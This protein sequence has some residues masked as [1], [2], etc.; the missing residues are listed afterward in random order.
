MNTQQTLQ[1]IQ[2]QLDDLQLSMRQNL[3]NVQSLQ[4]QV[5]RLMH[6]ATQKTQESKKA[7]KILIVTMPDNRQISYST[8]VQTFLTVIDKIGIEKVRILNLTSCGIPL[9]A[10]YRSETYVQQRKSICGKYWVTVHGSTE[11]KASGL[12][13]IASSLNINIEIEIVESQ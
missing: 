11:G 3:E 6:K 8:G 4:E 2:T 10:L 13:K 5:K 7:K 1:N 9:I 12:R